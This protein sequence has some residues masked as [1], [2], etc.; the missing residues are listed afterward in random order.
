MNQVTEMMHL[1]LARLRGKVAQLTEIADSY[2][3][4]AHAASQLMQDQEQRIA[5]LEREVA[6]LR[7]QLN[8]RREE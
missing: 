5:E 2:R 7:K 4:A 6:G 1:E 8:E 3:K